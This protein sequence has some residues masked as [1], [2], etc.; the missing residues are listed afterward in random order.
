MKKTKKTLNFGPHFINQNKKN[1]FT[2]RL[3]GSRSATNYGTVWIIDD[4]LFTGR[5]VRAAMN[6]VMDW[7]RPSQIRLAVIIDR[8]GR[9]LPIQADVVGR[10][11]DAFANQ[12]VEVLVPEVDERLGVEIVTGGAE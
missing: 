6:E 9:E 3:K 7:G 1:T 12:R 4:V 2:D 8:G 10:R 5:T 11:V